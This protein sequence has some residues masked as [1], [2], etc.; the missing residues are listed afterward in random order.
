MQIAQCSQIHGS[1]HFGTCFSGFFA[2]Y[3]QERLARL[4]FGS[5]YALDLPEFARYGSHARARYPFAAFGLYATHVTVL[6]HW[7]TWSCHGFTSLDETGRPLDQER[8]KPSGHGNMKTQKQVYAFT[9]LKAHYLL[10][11]ITF[12]IIH[13]QIVQTTVF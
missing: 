13:R 9:Y 2:A 8:K 7:D 10:L 5:A 3:R 1:V 6:P 11:F 4:L 12:F